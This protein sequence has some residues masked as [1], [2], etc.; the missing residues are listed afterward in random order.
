M[1]GPTSHPPVQAKKTCVRKLA[2]GLPPD[3]D[4]NQAADFLDCNKDIQSEKVA[5]RKDDRHAS[6]GP[7]NCDFRSES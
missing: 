3:P 6:Q 1:S 7:P 2:L 5:A 4:P